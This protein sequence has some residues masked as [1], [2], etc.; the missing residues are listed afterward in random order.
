MA[1]C[2]SSGGP[3]VMKL[4]GRLSLQCVVCMIF[5]SFVLEY[6]LILFLF[7][8][9]PLTSLKRNLQH[10]VWLRFLNQTDLLILLNEYQKMFERSFSKSKDLGDLLRYLPGVVVQKNMSMQ[11]MAELY[12][13][14][15]DLLE[16]LI[17][18][19]IEPLK[20]SPS[21]YILDRY[22]SDFL[23]DPGRSRLYYCDPMLQHIS[24]C[25]HFLSL[26]DR[27][28]TPDF[29]SQV[30]FTYFKLSFS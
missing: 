12:G 30:F 16:R 27:F 23:Q 25:R 22:L 14:I 9:L 17:V 7:L 26:L 2:K 21:H 13:I 11:G 8:R 6:V 29:Q 15:P 20:P 4:L 10:N 5:C 28:N 24:I 19:T 18:F 3:Q 1:S